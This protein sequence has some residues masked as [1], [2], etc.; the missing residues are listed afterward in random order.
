MQE[1]DSELLDRYRGG[2][3]A[4]LERLVRKHQHM[5]YGYIVN[6]TEGRDDADDIF[7]EVWFRAIR[8]LDG[9]RHRNF[10]GWLV[11]IA[12]NVV[13]DRARRRKPEVSLD[14]ENANGFSLADVLSADGPEPSAG[15]DAGPLGERIAGAV[16]TLPRDQREVFLMRVQANLPFKAIARA[17]R[18]SINTA[19]ARMQYALA[20]LRPLLK[21]AYAEH[22][23]S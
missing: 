20:K 17:Q 19:L 18:V 10:P 7:Q 8:R 9:Y 22:V 11:R 1:R 15:L 3:V 23:E 2:D 6:M 21:T 12:H 14:E 4:A 13:I 16:A 5:L